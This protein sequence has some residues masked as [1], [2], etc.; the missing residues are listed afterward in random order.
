MEGGAKPGFFLKDFVICLWHYLAEVGNGEKVLKK[1][2]KYRSML[3]PC[4]GCEL[5]GGG[6]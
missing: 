5:G 6:R 2:T 3:A 4:C 1:K